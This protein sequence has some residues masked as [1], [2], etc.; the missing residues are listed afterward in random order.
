ML[1]RAYVGSERAPLAEATRAHRLPP[2]TSYAGVDAVVDA[3]GR[4]PKRA[5]IVYRYF[6]DMAR[7]LA[8]AARVVRPGGRVVLVVCPS[9]IRKVP[10]ATHELFSEMAPLATGGT[11]SVEAMHARTIHDHRRVMPYLEASFGA[12][13]RT[14]YVLVLAKGKPRPCS[15]IDHA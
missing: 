2:P 10:V 1:G 7:V 15:S 3:L 4:E 14:E 6:Q 8:E 9:N 13:M 5:W 12:R 11:L